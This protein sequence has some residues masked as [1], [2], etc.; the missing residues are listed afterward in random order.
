MPRSAREYYAIMQ[1]SYG[2]DA[3][4]LKRAFRRLAK[5]YHPD[6]NAGNKSA[7]SKFKEINEAYSFLSDPDNIIPP[8]PEPAAQPRQTW[9]APREHYRR[10]TKP[11]KEESPEFDFYPEGGSGH[12]VEY[13]GM[14]FILILLALLALLVFLFPGPRSSQT[15]KNGTAVHVIHR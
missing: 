10:N 13:W 2:A 12:Q 9:Q 3:A 6:N 11:P 1:V 4:T 15:E 14:D 7:E 8:E 5:Q